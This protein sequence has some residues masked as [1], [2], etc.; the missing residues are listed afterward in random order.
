M[1]PK[2]K[3]L[4]A[5]LTLLSLLPLPAQTKEQSKEKSCRV[6]YLQ[7]PQDAPT[8]AYLFDGAVSH[9]VELP[10]MNFSD[11]VKLPAGDITLGM[12]PGPVDMPEN[13]PKGAPTLKVPAH[14]LDL[15]IIVGSDPA[16]AVFPVRML[17]LDVSTGKLKPGETMWVNL[18]GHRIEARLG[19]ES[20]DVPPKGRAVGKAPLKASGYYTVRFAYQPRDG[21][22]LLP[23]MSKSWWHDATSRHLG[24][25]IESGGR[26]PRIFTF[27]D[28]RDEANM[29][30]MQE[31][32]A[33]PVEE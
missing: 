33:D 11:V 24:F 30:A 3:F 2:M 1:F 31:E 17:A 16:N 28:Y 23:I 25:I 9:K 15:Y 10:G 8:E 21:M 19:K 18:T 13:F 22:E 5:S 14:V 29:E 4:V 32:Q 6:I 26:L 7:R 27:R 12:T 20:L